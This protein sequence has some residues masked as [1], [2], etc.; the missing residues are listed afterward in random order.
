MARSGSQWVISQAFVE[1]GGNVLTLYTANAYGSPSGGSLS[2]LNLASGKLQRI[3][4]SPAFFDTIFCTTTTGALVCGDVWG[5]KAATVSCFVGG[6][7]LNPE[8]SL[9]VSMHKVPRLAALELV[10]AGRLLSPSF[11]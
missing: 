11:T 10:V 6:V 7:H 8:L 3:A 1:P 4:S 9:L 2:E 5:R